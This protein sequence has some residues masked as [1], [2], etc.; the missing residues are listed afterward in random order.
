MVNFQFE[1]NTFY[2][3][4]QYHVRG[5]NGLNILDFMARYETKIMEARRGVFMI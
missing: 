2:G 5:T 1:S 4:V 3:L